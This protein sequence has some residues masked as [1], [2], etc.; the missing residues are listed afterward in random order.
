MRTIAIAFTLTTTAY[1]LPALAAITAVGGAAV[2][3]GPPA[4]VN[5]DALESNTSA[6]VFP[7]RQGFFLPVP[8]SV[9]IT[10][11]GLVSSAGDLTPAT[12]PAGARV[13]S[14]LIHSDPVA[15]GTA[16]YEGFVEFDETIIGLIVLRS[17]LGA[18]DFIGNPLTTYADYAA[19]GMELG[20]DQVRLVV[21]RSRVDFRFNTSGAT[22]DIRVITLVPTP[23]STA[24]LGLGGLIAI[25]RRR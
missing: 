12:I 20:N 9:D 22:D 2:Q 17:T 6:F 18:S 19:R 5:L 11:V 23:A 16:L 15:S 10:A 1:T 3:I 25:R 4:S 8:L 24:L 21:G 14:Y 7:E 13:S